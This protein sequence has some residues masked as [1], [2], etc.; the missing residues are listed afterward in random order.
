MENREDKIES[1]YQKN[2]EFVLKQRV[3]NLLREF[4]ENSDGRKR[5][6]RLTN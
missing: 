1:I 6:T 5:K 3:E 4:R 2:A